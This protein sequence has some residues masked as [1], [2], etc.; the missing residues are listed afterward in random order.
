MTEEQKPSRDVLD[1][2]EVLGQQLTTAVKTLWESEESRK[3]RQDL[4]QGFIQLGQ[5]IDEAVKSAQE[6]DAARQ[7]GEQVK[8]TVGKARHSDV[9]AQIEEG[10][11]T[12][13]RKMNQELSKLISSLEEDDGGA[14]ET[15]PEAETETRA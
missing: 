12:G 4:R 1:E 2:L 3:L 5:E 11:A 15:P 7:F 6:S 14:G 10:L 8:E 9:T 13:L